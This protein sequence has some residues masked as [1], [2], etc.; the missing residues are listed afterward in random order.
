[1]KMPIPNDWDGVSFCDYV[2]RWPNSTL[3]RIILRG[4]CS[5]PSIAAFWDERTGDVPEVIEQFEEALNYLVDELRC[6]TMISVPIGSYFPFAGATAPENFLLCDGE[7]YFTADYPELFGVIAR[8]Y[9]G[10]ELF[11]TFRVPDLR[12]RVPVGKNPS[13]TS[14]DALGEEGGEET[15]SLTTSQIPSHAHEGYRYVGSGGTHNWSISGGGNNGSTLTTSSTGSG[16][17]H[18]NLQPYI[19]ANY[20]IRAM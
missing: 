8:I 12:G 17:A 9:G 18:N 16:S 5:N 20:I 10:S 2:V 3:W 11:G 7:E 4:V 13:H 15:V 14:F 1:M 6:E 19:V